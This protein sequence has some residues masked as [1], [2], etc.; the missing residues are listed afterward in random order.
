M[1]STAL[2]FLFNRLEIPISR[3]AEPRE[4]QELGLSNISDA[5]ALSVAFS[6]RC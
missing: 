4:A 1:L 3:P 2:I 5:K 6:I